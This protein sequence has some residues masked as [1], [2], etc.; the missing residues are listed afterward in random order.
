MDAVPPALAGWFTGSDGRTPIEVRYASRHSL[1]VTLDGGP[2]P[3]EVDL[4]LE[5]KNQRVAIGPCRLLTDPADQGNGLR[6]LVPIRGVH[7]TDS[8]AGAETML[9]CYLDRDYEPSGFVKLSFKFFRHS[10]TL[11]KLVPLDR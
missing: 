7:D 9:L 3:E 2:E 11:L 10:C 1:W 4:E 8:C 6:R 5:V